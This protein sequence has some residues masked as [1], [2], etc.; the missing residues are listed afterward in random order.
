MRTE[1]VGVAEELNVGAESRFAK[2]VR[3]EVVLILLNLSEDLQISSS[4]YWIT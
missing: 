2:A 1:L 4:Q 3:V